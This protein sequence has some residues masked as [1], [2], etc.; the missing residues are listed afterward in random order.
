MSDVELKISLQLEESNRKLDALAGKFDKANARGKKFADDQAKASAKTG[1][2]LDG[3]ITKVGALGAAY[4]TTAG[5]AKAFGIAASSARVQDSIKI[6]EASGGSIAELRKQTKGFVTDATLAKN[7]NLARIMGIN[8]EEFGRLANMARAAAKLT[9]ESTEFMLDSVVKG[10][11]R[12]SKLLLDNLGILVDVKGANKAYAKQL[13][14]NVKA[15]TD[16]QKKRAFK[17]EVLKKEEEMVKSVTDAGATQSDIYD[18]LEVSLSNLADTFGQ[19]LG[20]AV[21]S[22]I[23]PLNDVANWMRDIL[24]LSNEMEGGTAISGKA[25]ARAFQLKRAQNLGSRLGL[26]AAATLGQLRAKAGSLKAEDNA[27]ASESTIRGIKMLRDTLRAYDALNKEVG[28]MA[29][30]QKRGKKG[31]RGRGRGAG[32]SSFVED[33]ALDFGRAE[34]TAITDELA[35]A[36]AE[37]A[38][39]DAEAAAYADEQLSIQRRENRAMERDQEIG[40]EA[41]RMDAKRA[42]MELERFNHEERRA[43]ND[44]AQAWT[45]HGINTAVNLAQSGIQ[46]LADEQDHILERLGIQALAEVGNILVAEGTR[47]AAEGAALLIKSG[48]TDPRGYAMAGLATGAIA[49]GVGMGGAAAF[50]SAHFARMDAGSSDSVGSNAT[51]VRTSASRATSSGTDSGFNLTVV[52]NGVG[53]GADEQAKAFAKLADTAKRKGY[54]P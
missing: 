34:D 1:K 12:G 48:G 49:A 6:L 28:Q 26:P 52:Y 53:P 10:T 40:L 39:I 7:A 36:R 17:L 5:A 19:A 29:V 15:L 42:E 45:M 35:A 43:M 2:S 37:E 9:G 18:R 4:L 3:L 14:L 11:A 38:R 16:E 8:A 44:E 20:P 41:G 21:T 24:N 32:K 13:G 46:M 30:V 27:G 23:Q 33:S 51:R 47:Y 22:V 50:G 31:R 54:L 25:Q